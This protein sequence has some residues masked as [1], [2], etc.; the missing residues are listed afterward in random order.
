MSQ[1]ELRT[2]APALEVR[3]LEVDTGV[4]TEL[5]GRAVPYDEWSDVGWYLE[6]HAR[7]SLTRSIEQSKRALPLLLWHEMAQWP[8]GH[9][10]SW[11]T[12]GTGLDGVWRL[13][14]SLEAQRA[15]AMAKDGHLTGMSI[16]FIPLRTE[17]TILADDEWDP[18]DGKKD[19]YLRVESR[20]AETSVVPTGQFYDAKVKLVRTAEVPPA[21]RGEIETPALDYWRRVRATL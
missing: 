12:E 9:A 14:G 21:G 6:A 17:R 7:G 19:R 15:A 18:D 16:G 13:D 20:L 11:S 5:L 10:A 1:T 4:F 8:I 3:A 2:Y